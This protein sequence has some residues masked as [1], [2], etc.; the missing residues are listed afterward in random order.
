MSQVKW[1]IGVRR[2][3]FNHYQRSVGRGLFLSI[4]IIGIDVVEQF[5]PCGVGYRE[6]KKSLNH[7][8][9]GD[10]LA[11]VLETAAYL[12]GRILG[13]FLGK[14]QERKHNQRKIGRASC[15]ERV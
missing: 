4:K 14:F 7:I 1:L 3:V 5:H 6:V 15:R 2:T 13:L 10:G 9:S 11:V 12:L 8:K